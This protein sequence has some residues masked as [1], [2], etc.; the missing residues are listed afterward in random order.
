MKVTTIKEAHDINTMRVDELVSS[1]QIFELA[2]GDKYDKN[3]KSLAFVSNAKDE[4]GQVNLDTDEGKSDVENISSDISKKYESQNENNTKGVQCKEYKGFGHVR[5]ECPTYVKKKQKKDDLVKSAKESSQKEI[6][7]DKSIRKLVS[8]IAMGKAT[9]NDASDF[10]TSEKYT[11]VNIFEF[12]HEANAK[13]CEKE[14]VDQNI[15]NN[16]ECGSDDKPIVEKLAPGLVKILKKR[17]TK[18]TENTISKLFKTNTI[19][20]PTKGWSKVLLPSSKKKDLKRKND[21]SSN[22]EF[23]VD[24]NVKDIL[25]NIQGKFVT[26]KSLE[27]IPDIPLDNMSFHLLENAKKWKYIHHNRISLERELEKDALECKEVIDHINNVGLIKIMTKLGRSEEEQLKVEVSDNTICRKIAGNQVKEWPRKDKLSA[28]YVSVK[29]AI[30]Q[31]IGAANW[32][33]TNHTPSIAIGLG[34]FIYIVKNKTSYDFGT[35]IFDQIMKQDIFYSV[36]MPIVFPTLICGIIPSQHP[37]IIT[38]SDN[39]CKRESPLS[40]H[41]KLFE[42]TRVLDIVMTFAK[43]NVASTSKDDIFACQK[44]K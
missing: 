30:L 37:R 25:Q 21:A 10:L 15:V 42:G 44:V 34:N 36:K 17:K 24:T 32:V 19:M 12:W 29:Y 35:Y 26:K 38:E 1:L 14:D 23:D 6:S 3:N 31:K 4:K 27:N 40:F 18:T 9:A 22:S 43:E 16:E 8:D 41:P 20:G 33:T 7:I 39:V 28:S 11:E 2:N 13:T 5:I